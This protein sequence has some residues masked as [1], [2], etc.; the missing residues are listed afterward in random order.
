MYW[1]RFIS[2][3]PES[4]HERFG[5]GQPLNLLQWLSLCILISYVKRNKG[6]VE[7]TGATTLLPLFLN[8]ILPLPFFLL[9]T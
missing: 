8:I 7:E 2:S 5:K 3:A 6:K 9:L 4:V 1:V